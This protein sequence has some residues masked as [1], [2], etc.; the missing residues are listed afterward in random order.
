MQPSYPT[1][2]GPPAGAAWRR[3]AGAIAVLGLAAAGVVYLRTSPPDNSV[4]PGYLPPE[5]TKIYDLEMERIG[6][7]ANLFAYEITSWIEGLWHGRNL[8]AT[9]GVLSVAIAL[10]C[11]AIGWLLERYPPE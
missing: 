2:S 4:I 1:A 6:G 5:D 8:A 10:A 3:A 7:K 11:F 9:L